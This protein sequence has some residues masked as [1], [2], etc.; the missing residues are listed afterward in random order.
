MIQPMDPTEDFIKDVLKVLKNTEETEGRIVRSGKTRSNLGPLKRGYI[1]I[2]RRAVMV[3]AQPSAY[4]S[5]TPHAPK[6]NVQ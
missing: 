1:I 5:S 4:P 6:A 2:P 3:M